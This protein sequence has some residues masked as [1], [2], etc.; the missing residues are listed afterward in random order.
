MIISRSDALTSLYLGLLKRFI[1]PRSN[2]IGALDL[3][4]ELRLHAI[5]RSFMA[6]LRPCGRPEGKAYS[7]VS[8]ARPRS[9]KAIGQGAGRMASPAST[10]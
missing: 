9:C 2:L 6:R 3:A 1:L 7:D 5:F 4:Y 10:R 8:K